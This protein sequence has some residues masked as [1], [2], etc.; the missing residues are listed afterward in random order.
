MKPLERE[1]PKDKQR[2]QKSDPK[3]NSA[4]KPSPRRPSGAKWARRRRC[5]PFRASPC[6]SV[7]SAQAPSR[8]R[9][10][11]GKQ[12]RPKESD[13]KYPLEQAHGIRLPMRIDGATDGWRRTPYVLHI[14]RLRTAAKKLR[15][16][17]IR[18]YHRPE[19]AFKSIRCS[20]S[21]QPPIFWGASSHQ[22]GVH[23]YSVEVKY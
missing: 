11:E 13:L 12:K 16:A 7:A 14:E 9:E 19:R 4:M 22:K 17:H 23:C 5:L 3:P 20:L 15:H 18:E 2:R 6:W 8:R 10:A 21:R 1:D